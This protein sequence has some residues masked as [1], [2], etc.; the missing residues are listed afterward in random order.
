MKNCVFNCSL[1]M[2]RYGV[3]HWTVI[4][5]SLA[6]PIW[7][8][9]YPFPISCPLPTDLQL[10]V[11]ICVHITSLCWEFLCFEILITCACWLGYRC[12]KATLYPESL[13]LYIN[14]EFL[15][16]IFILFIFLDDN[17]ALELMAYN[18]CHTKVKQGPWLLFSLINFYC[19]LN[20][21]D[22]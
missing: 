18:R 11:G 19:F 17:N 4:K 7:K 9:D 2:T 21:Y 16:L 8:S 12:R 10:L 6:T 22:S 5:K 13:S 3:I 1:S 15:T 20:H 14:F